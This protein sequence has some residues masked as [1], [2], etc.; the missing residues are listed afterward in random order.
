MRIGHDGAKNKIITPEI[1][2]RKILSGCAKNDN[3]NLEVNTLDKNQQE[4]PGIT[5]WSR[6]NRLPIHPSRAASQADLRWME[7]G[8]WIVVEAGMDVKELP[9]GHY[10]AKAIAE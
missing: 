1:V 9:G 2:V 8:K 7:W 6:L 5:G 10:N 3:H 4:L